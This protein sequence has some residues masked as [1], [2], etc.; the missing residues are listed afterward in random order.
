MVKEPRPGKVKTRLGNDIGMVNAA[1]WYQA[2]K[3]V[4]SALRYTS[5]MEHSNCCDAR[6]RRDDEVEFGHVN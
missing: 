2:P 4:N 6:Y 3:L 1:W 5:K